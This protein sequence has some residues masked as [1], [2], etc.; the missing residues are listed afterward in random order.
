MTAYRPAIIACDNIG[1]FNLFGR[2]PMDAWVSSTRENA[3]KEGWSTEEVPREQTV[4]KNVS[5]RLDLCPTCTD[6]LRSKQDVNSAS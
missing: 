2:L 6:L 4:E 1:C 3:A 5:R